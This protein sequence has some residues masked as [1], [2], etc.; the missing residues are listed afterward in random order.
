MFTDIEGE[1]G[2]ET[3]FEYLKREDVDVM[4]YRVEEYGISWQS[5]RSWRMMG[6]R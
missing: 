3:S 6:C 4:P 5:E 2:I 1:E